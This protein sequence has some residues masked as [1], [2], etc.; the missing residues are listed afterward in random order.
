MQRHGPV[1]LR[2]GHAK[3]ERNGHH[4]HDLRG[5]SAENVTAEHFVRI[6][7]DQILSLS[8]KFLLPV[9]LTLLIATSFVV[10]WRADGF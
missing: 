8:W 5:V 7:V 10:V 9:T 6:R 2:L 4:L 1:E 3:L